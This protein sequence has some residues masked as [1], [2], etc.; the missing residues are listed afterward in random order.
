MKKIFLSAI[1]IISCF[2]NFH[3]NENRYNDLTLTNI[4]ALA[5]GESGDI[6]THCYKYI[7]SSEPGVGKFIKYC[8]G[9]QSL[10]ATNWSNESFCL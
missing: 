10:Y 1:I 2:I 3:I 6:T 8:G 4:E 5:Q 9:C 7:S